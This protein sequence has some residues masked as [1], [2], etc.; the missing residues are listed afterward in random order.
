MAIKQTPK[1]K[2]IKAKIK[3]KIHTIMIMKTLTLKINLMLINTQAS[4]HL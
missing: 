1:T 4:D 3:N 2:N